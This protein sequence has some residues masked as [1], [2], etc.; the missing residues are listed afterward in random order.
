M[1][2]KYE[3]IERFREVATHGGRSQTK[4]TKEN[5]QQSQTIRK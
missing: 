4:Q 3:C 2:M 5:N 1:N